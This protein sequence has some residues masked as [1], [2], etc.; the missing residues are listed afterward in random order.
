MESL[1]VSLPQQL[2]DIPVFSDLPQED[3]LWLASL[4]EVVH[5][6]PGDVVVAERAHQ[7]R[8]A[9]VDLTIEVPRHQYVARCVNHDT[10]AIVAARDAEPLWADVVTVDRRLRS[11]AS[12]VIGGMAVKPRPQSKPALGAESPSR[13]TA[14]DA[15]RAVRLRTWRSAA[16]TRAAH[17]ARVNRCQS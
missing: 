5:Y 16:R 13:A 1:A 11:A 8:A 3:L 2:K 9:K 10:I 14:S 17:S 12:A 6:K 7:R 4:M 15:H